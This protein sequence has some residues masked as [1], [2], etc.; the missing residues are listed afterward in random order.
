MSE[1]LC[2]KWNDFQTNINSAFG[3]LRND[4]NFSDVTLACEDGQQME[5]HKVILAASSPF[6]ENLLKM[7]KHAHPL[8]YMRG[9]KSDDLVAIIDFLYYGET[10]VNQEKLDVFLAIA[11][12]LKLKGLS[13][14]EFP[15]SP[16][17]LSQNIND[18]LEERSEK[19]KT[20]FVPKV[21]QP[22]NDTMLKLV[23]VKQESYNSVVFS[24]HENYDVNVTYLQEL[25]EKVKSMMTKSESAG[26]NGPGGSTRASVCT[27]CGKE[28]KSG[29]IKDHIEVHHLEGVSIPCNYCEK[30]FRTRDAL[31]HHNSRQ[32]K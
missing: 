6:F 10:N 29:H 14:G 27:V 18:K 11:E 9:V 15:I 30:T 17:S 26:P 8:I 32:H 31:R 28:G 12:E 20:D 22:E 19:P 7:N 13:Q 4:I 5:A 2:L 24:N 25:D 21:L 1:K 16:I 23:P 3:S